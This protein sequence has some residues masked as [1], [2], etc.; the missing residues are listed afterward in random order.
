MA[1]AKIKAVIRAVILAWATLSMAC[2]AMAQEWQLLDAAHQ[3]VLAPLQDNWAQLHPERK[4][5]WVD[6]AKLHGNLSPSAQE[7]LRERMQHW[8]SLSN[9]ERAQVIESYK[10]HKQRSPQAQRDIEQQWR[11]YQAL[12]EEEKAR[13]RAMTKG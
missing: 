11:E 10:Q 12:P 2:I 6:I 13:L 4:K 9:A 5:V 3:R 1:T 7:R 8:E